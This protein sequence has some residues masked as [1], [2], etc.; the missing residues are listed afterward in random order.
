MTDADRLYPDDISA[1]TGPVSDE[2]ARVRRSASLIIGMS[3][4]LP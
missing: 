2:D 1:A 4:A 3:A